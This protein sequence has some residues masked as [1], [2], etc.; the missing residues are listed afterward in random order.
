M[1]GARPPAAATGGVPAAGTPCAAGGSGTWTVSPLVAG[2]HGAD[3]RLHRT[4]GKK[5]VRRWRSRDA[6]VTSVTTV[7]LSLSAA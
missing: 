2:T 5:E 3:D 7:W 4:A 6:C 1:H